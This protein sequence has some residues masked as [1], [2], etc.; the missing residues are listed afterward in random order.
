MVTREEIEHVSKLM[1]IELDDHAI[2]IE[3]V[4]KMI[5]YFDILDSAGVESEDISVQEIPIS[6]L[7]ED[8]YI[9]F[10]R[11]VLDFY[12][13][14]QTS[15]RTIGI[16]SNF[17]DTKRNTDSKSIGLHKKHLKKQKISEIME[18]AGDLMEKL[19]Y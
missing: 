15:L 1:R 17:D 6:S 4:Q 11:S 12:K 8:T 7:R 9:P 2:H 18:V 19:E 3:R 10:D 14:P 5:E 16:A 13:M